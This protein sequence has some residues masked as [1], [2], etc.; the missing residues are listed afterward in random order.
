MNWGINLERLWEASDADLADAYQ[1]A[2]ER[3]HNA[4][5]SLPGSPSDA[6]ARHSREAFL[7][8]NEIARRKD[9]S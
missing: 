3:A 1:R 8:G 9:A 6:W 2:L 7:L 4:P 5:K